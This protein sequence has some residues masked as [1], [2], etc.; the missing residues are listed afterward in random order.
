MGCIEIFVDS[1]VEYQDRNGLDSHMPV[2]LPSFAKWST[3]KLS[4]SS[5]NLKSL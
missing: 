3:A 5:G 2:T 1:K 4:G